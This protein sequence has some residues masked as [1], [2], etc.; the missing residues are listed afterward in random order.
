MVAAGSRLGAGRH[1]QR[2]RIRST[3]VFSRP[4]VG[5]PVR[6][7]HGNDTRRTGV[8]RSDPVEL[9]V[10]DGLAGGRRVAAAGIAASVGL[11]TMNIL[12]GLR[13]QSVSVVATGFEFAG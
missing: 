1:L 7:A 9:A 11:A 8:G 6:H 13:T 10:N 12:I 3:A 5:A 2:Q 4:A